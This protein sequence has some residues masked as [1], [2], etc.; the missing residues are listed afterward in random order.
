MSTPYLNLTDAAGKVAAFSTAVRLGLLDRIDREPADPAELARTC[1]ATERGVRVVLAALAEGGFVEQLPDGRYRPVL[2]GLAALH[3]LI[4]LWDHLPDAVRTGIPVYD[5]NSASPGNAIY[6]RT[7]AFLAG[8]WGDAVDQAITTLPAATRILDVGAGS[9]PWT[10]SYCQRYP[11]SHVTAL[12]LPEILPSTR[13][14]ITRAGL[15]DRYTFLAGDVLTTPLEPCT[16]DLIVVA[17]VCSLF[18]RSNGSALIKRLTPA[19]AAGGVLAI[20]DTLAGSPGS[21]MQELSLYLRTQAGA[22]HQPDAYHGWLADAG[23]T[24]ITSTDLP[25]KLAITVLTGRKSQQVASV[26][27]R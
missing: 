26:H 4:P 1:G 25:T 15:T 17:Q 16:Y 24:E 8:L 27:D 23:L 7:M 2:T 22:V 11:E 12:D 13:R 20:I 9:E 14:A 3:P 18:D 21:A 10:I 19:L 5:A 6:P